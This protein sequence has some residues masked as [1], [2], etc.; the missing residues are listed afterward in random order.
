MCLGNILKYFTINSKKSTIKRNC[1][2]FPVD[3]NL[4]DV[5]AILDIH[6]YLMVKHDIRQCLG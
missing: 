2:F 1:N 3:F 6:K 4:I 5:N